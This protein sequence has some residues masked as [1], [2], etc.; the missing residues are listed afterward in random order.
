M[1]NII[2][3][4][5]DWKNARFVF[6]QSWESVQKY[7][8]CLIHL[9]DKHT[10]NKNIKNEELFNECIPLPNDI[11]GLYNMVLQVHKNIEIINKAAEKYRAT[12]CF[13][14]YGKEQRQCINFS[15]NDSL[16]SDIRCNTCPQFMFL[17]HF[18]K[19][20][21]DVT[22]KEKQY[23]TAKQKLLDNFRFWKTK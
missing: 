11:D 4:F 12:G 5:K 2:Q 1:T 20:N 16:Q 21:Y 19:L 22:K 13:Y 7:K 8:H 6:K 23:Q 17:K 3:D 10:W 15:P 14:E 18:Q 9:C